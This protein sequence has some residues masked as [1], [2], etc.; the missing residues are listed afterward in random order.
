MIEE[1]KYTVEK[2][3]YFRIVFVALYCYGDWLENKC[4]VFLIFIFQNYWNVC[5]RG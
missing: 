3:A 2:M 5:E 4:V 1:N